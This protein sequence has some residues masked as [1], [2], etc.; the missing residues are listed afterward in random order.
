[1]IIITVFDLNKNTKKFIEERAQFEK[2]LNINDDEQIENNK[3]ILNE[4]N[5]PQVYK[6]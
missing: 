5:D 4:E 3:N 6:Y 2:D 1:V